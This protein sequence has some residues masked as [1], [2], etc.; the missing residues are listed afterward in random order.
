[1]MSRCYP[2]T[3]CF[4]PFIENLITE[5]RNA[6]FQYEHAEWRLHK[7]DEFCNQ[8]LIKTPVITKELAE[9][10]GTLRK[11][12]TKVT[13]AGRISIL[14][15]LSLY[16]QAYGIQCYVPRNYSHKS[17]HIAYVL[18]IE[19]IQSLFREI[20]SYQPAVNA[21]TFHRLALEYRILFR[22]LFCCGLRASEARKLRLDM[23]DLENGVLRIYQSKGHNDRLVYLPDDLRQL[24]CDYLKIM[25]VKYKI[26]SE[27]FFPAS[28][29]A[30]VLQ[31]A[32]IG[33]RFRLAWGQTPYARKGGVQPTVHSLR[34]TFVVLRMNE[35]M[36]TGVKL[37]NMMPYLS[38][39]L[40][41]SSPDDTFYYYHQVEEAFS[42]IR[43]KDQSAAFVIPEVT[44]EK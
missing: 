43:Q 34:H 29:P 14:R 19:E 13:L 10:W 20:D 40:G 18:S 24:C 33:K 12:E 25:T 30:K 3:S 17:S 15:Q 7:F 8:E 44:D 28:D 38:K 26:R 22:M 5:K 23:A 1:M 31:V 36:K 32:S 9:K 4:A 39:Y 11:T 2:F 21:E 35:W 27:W 41:H 16:M 6:G 42:I 37:D